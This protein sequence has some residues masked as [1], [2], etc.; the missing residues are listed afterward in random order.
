LNEA[1]TILEGWITENP[2]QWLWVH[3]RWK[4]EE[5]RDVT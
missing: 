4:A 3:K 2:S 5:L 1:H